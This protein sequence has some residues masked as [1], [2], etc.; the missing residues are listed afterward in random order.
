MMASVISHHDRRYR[1][2]GGISWYHD[3]LII[4]WGGVVEHRY[5]KPKVLT[6]AFSLSA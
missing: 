6:N 2:A 4:S 5:I 3:H 1:R